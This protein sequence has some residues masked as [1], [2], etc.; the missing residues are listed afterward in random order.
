MRSIS[1]LIG[2]ISITASL[3]I[4]NSKPRTA[5]HGRAR[6]RLKEGEVEGRIEGEASGY[7][8]YSDNRRNYETAA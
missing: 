1:I 4:L 3:Q 5:K 8:N 7:T 6:I 2:L